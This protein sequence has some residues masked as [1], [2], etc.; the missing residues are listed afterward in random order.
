MVCRFSRA[1]EK[2]IWQGYS[3]FVLLGVFSVSCFLLHHLDS[4]LSG[5]AV[6]R[7]KGSAAGVWV[8]IPPFAGMKPVLCCGVFCIAH[9]SAKS[10]CIDG[11][12]NVFQ[13]FSFGVI[14]FLLDF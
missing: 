9:S 14:W 7:L 6:L 10:S 11:Y 13:V 12:L 5:A 1:R 2:E 4:V 3:F 8:F